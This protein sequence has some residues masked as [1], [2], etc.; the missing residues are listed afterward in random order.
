MANLKIR[1]SSSVS[2]SCG[3]DITF[4]GGE[5]FP[6]TNNITLGTGIGEVRIDFSAGNNPDKFIV[7][8]TRNNTIIYDSG[9]LGYSGYQPQLSSFLSSNGLPDETIISNSHNTI[10]VFIFDKTE[11]ESYNIRIDVYSPLSGTA[12]KY[13]IG[14]PAEYI[15][16]PNK[17]L[18]GS[19][20]DSVYETF[21]NAI[22]TTYTN[23]QKV[24]SKHKVILIP[25]VNQQDIIDKYNSYIQSNNIP[26]FSIFIPQELVGSIA[27]LKMNPIINNSINT[28]S[29][30]SYG[31]GGY[32]NDFNDI[33]NLNNKDIVEYDISSISNTSITVLDYNI[34]LYSY[35]KNPISIPSR[36]ASAILVK[37][38][39]LDISNVEQNLFYFAPVG[40]NLT[41]TRQVKKQNIFD[42]DNIREFFFTG[43]YAVG[44]IHGILNQ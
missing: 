18:V 41:R 22:V 19:Q 21:N 5:S 11:N 9:Y 12:F 24:F 17:I 15:N 31:I 40:I 14:C 25:Y 16:I 3:G 7:T 29:N 44:G 8:D 6:S 36:V 13:N 43:P 39:V 23:S 34:G 37:I 4:V 35:L 33:N 10:K 20:N 1:V 27:K 38:S 30:T 42:L 32:H 26:A 28:Q 2:T